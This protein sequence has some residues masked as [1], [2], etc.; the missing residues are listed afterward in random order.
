[1]STWQEIA[2]AETFLKKKLREY[3]TQSNVP[4]L[5]AVLVRDAGSTI[6]A[7]QQGIRKVGAT[8]DQN[9]VQDTDRFNI[10]SIS[11]IFAAHL[12]G[13]LIEAKK[14]GVPWESLS[15][16]STLGK[17]IPDLT[18]PNPPYKDVT[19]DQYTAHVSGMPYSPSNE[20]SGVF[21]PEKDYPNLM[22]TGLNAFQRRMAYV[23]KAIQDPLITKCKQPADSQCKSGIHDP[24]VAGEAPCK[25][26]DCVNYSGGQV[27][28]AAMIER[29]T[30]MTFEDLIQQYVFGPLN[31]TRSRFGRASFG[32]L[33][34]PWQHKWNPSTLKAE[35]FADAQ[36]PAADTM[37]RNP[38]G[39]MCCSAT[40]LGRFLAESI[41]PNPQLFPTTLQSM[42]TYLPA[43][44]ISPF[45]RGAWSSNMP[46]SSLDY[47]GDDSASLATVSLFLTSKTGVGAMCNMSSDA[48]LPNKLA[49]AGIVDMYNTALAFDAHWEELFGPG[50]PEPLEC[51]HGM[52]ALVA[53]GSS[54]NALT[55]FGRQRNGVVV[56]RQSDNGGKIWGAPVPMPGWIMTSGISAA[57]PPDGYPMYLFGRGTDNQIWF[58]KWPG[59]RQDWQGSWPAPFGTFMTG[60]AVAAS[61]NPQGVGLHLVAIGMDR[62]MYYV[63]SAN[64]GQNWSAVEAIGQGTFTSAP[65][66]AVSNDGTLVY[67]FGRGDDWRIWYNWNAE[68]GWQPHWTPIGE[69]IFSSGPGATSSKDG[70]RLHVMG[71]GMDSD[72]WHNW[73]NGA[74]QPFQ[75][76]WNKL[77]S[78]SFI[79][80]PALAADAPGQNL[81]VAALG[82]DFTIYTNHTASVGAPWDGSTQV[83]PNPGFFI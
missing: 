26:G 78:G 40:D 65:A 62:R 20:P 66:I 49:N 32:D 44:G 10:G 13:A 19:I 41:R 34:G 73:T 17:V 58:A 5:G 54:G 53:T 37:P 12:I 21:E 42:Q 7:G 28:N 79:S 30:G 68:A 60:P 69:G 74:G 77:S 82:D 27:I 38:V 23:L 9:V 50:A 81:Y 61:S 43:P 48:A 67:V 24:G 16:G 57:A 4:A 18:F 35:P 31:M 59:G 33:D 1:M 45:Y 72:M 15:W 6:V 2:A 55:V 75:P 47:T 46:G 51:V 22:L 64:G 3:V 29:L 52:P 80:A 14:P 39:G 63:Y 8:G 11:K 76:H 56:R 71:R 83:G 70:T 36:S 25:P